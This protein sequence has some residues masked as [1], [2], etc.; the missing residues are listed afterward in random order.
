MPRINFQ[1]IRS[2]FFRALSGTALLFALLLPCIA[3]SA[4]TACYTPWS[5]GTVYTGGETASYSGEN[6][7]ADY[8]TQNQNP[9]TNSGAVGT[10]EP[11]IP[12]GSCGAVTAYEQE[13]AE[14][15][16]TLQQWYVQSSGLYQSPTGWWNAANA[17][18]LLVNYSR[19]TGSTQ[20][21]SAVANT[22]ANA[23]AANGSQ[24]FITSANDD[25]GWWALAWVDAYDLTQNQD[26][27]NTAET[28]FSDLTTQW[29]TTT[30][31]GGVWWSKNLT[32]SAYKNAVTN[33]IFLKLAAS[34][35]NRVSD[36]T[37]KAQYLNWAEEEW[38]WF[39]NSGMINSQ[40][41]INDGL[42]ATNPNA[43]TNN[44]QTTWTYNQGVILGGLLE[45]YNANQDSSAITTAQAIASATMTNL[46]TSSGILQEPSISGPDQPQFKGIFIRNLMELDEAFPQAQYQTFV[47]NNV[48]SIWQNDQSSNYE[49]GVYWQGPF[50]SA[51]ATR[52]TSALD[53]FVAAIEMQNSSQ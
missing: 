22:Y 47:D 46:V 48:N 33:E 26:Y 14:G 6:Y 51:D 42:N 50:D 21:L 29:D 27:L 8:W 13:A 20:Y 17:I 44:G 49:F 40:N 35:A 15:V 12:D 41:L 9:S 38:Q 28:I 11:W 24:N 52:Q 16:T 10:G 4:Q 31:G 39:Q 1:T 7:T 19:V 43:C 30:C 23:N 37:A 2:F 34:L 3:A 25:E 18:T 5:A 36:P 32:T 53:A 45:L